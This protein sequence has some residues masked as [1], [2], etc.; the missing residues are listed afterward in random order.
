MN[1]AKAIGLLAASMVLMSLVA[2]YSSATVVSSGRVAVVAPDRALLAAEAHTVDIFE[3]EQLF[4]EKALTVTN[5]LAR[6]ARVEVTVA[7]D[8]SDP[9]DGDGDPDNVWTGPDRT[10][11]V[12]AGSSKIIYFGY[13]GKGADPGEHRV[14]YRV[15]AE[16]GGVRVLL[17]AKGIVKVLEV[18]KPAP[19]SDAADRSV[20]QGTPAATPGT[21][22]RDG[23]P[24]KPI[25]PSTSSGAGADNGA[26]VISG[27][28]SR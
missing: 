12:P 3:G 21:Q 28:R 27:G 4:S 11:T 10:E 20:P 8:P 17:F 25:G 15:K 19:P 26:K 14:T 16:A 22:G 13:T 9:S 18:P 1:V 7:D 2:A 24:S 5:R 6:D 23:P